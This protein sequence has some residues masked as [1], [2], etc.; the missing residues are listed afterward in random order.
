MES[1]CLTLAAGL[2]SSIVAM[3]IYIRQLHGARIDDLRARVQVERDC[4]RHAEQARID[5][6]A[7]F[8]AL[9]NRLGE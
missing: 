4:A 2:G 1:Q 5:A 3:A 7:Q 9:I 8:D 6:M